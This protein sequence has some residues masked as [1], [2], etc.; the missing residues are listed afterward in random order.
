[1]ASRGPPKP[2]PKPKSANRNRYARGPRTDNDPYTNRTGPRP[3]P[4]DLYP[5][6]RPEPTLVD[7]VARAKARQYLSMAIGYYTAK[8][9][10]RQWRAGDP[11]LFSARMDAYT[12]RQYQTFL[13]NV[14]ADT[15]RFLDQSYR[16]H[17]TGNP[18]VPSIDAYHM[19]LLAE[20]LAWSVIRPH[21]T[22]PQFRYS[23]LENLK[24]FRDAVQYYVEFIQRNPT[25]NLQV[26]RDI[27]DQMPFTDP[28][29]VHHQSLT[30]PWLTQEALTEGTPAWHD[31]FPNL[32]ALHLRRRTGQPT[33]KQPDFVLHPPPEVYDLNRVLNRNERF[34]RAE[35]RSQ[36]SSQVVDVDAPAVVPKKEEEEQEEEMEEIRREEALTLSEP[37]IDDIDEFPE[38]AEPV[39]GNDP[40]ETQLEPEPSQSSS[41]VGWAQGM[42][43]LPAPASSTPRGPEVDDFRLLLASSEPV[44]ALEAPPLPPAK[45]PAHSPVG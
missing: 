43:I 3:Q 14:L 22:K 26:L 25:G 44:L 32:P 35:A 36:G 23:H 40:D 17:L 4:R 15:R 38:E 29:D 18:H 24:E 8:Y 31:Q 5:Q 13:H 20:D 11:P 1:M 2:Q 16:T 30:P 19:R 42:G 45:P 34:K 6:G 10:W 9:Y 12:K 21:K 27:R 33:T 28:D 37:W 41:A 7:L 39:T